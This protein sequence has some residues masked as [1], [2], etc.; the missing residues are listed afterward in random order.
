MDTIIKIKASILPD[1]MPTINK[2]LQIQINELTTLG[3]LEYIKLKIK[4]MQAW[5]KKEH[6]YKN[7]E[8]T[9][10]INVKKK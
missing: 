5:Y 8:R 10:K 3:D 2:H 9:K 7:C 6:K 4:A 1:Y